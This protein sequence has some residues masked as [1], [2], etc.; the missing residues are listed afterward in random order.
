[1]LFYAIGERTISLSWSL[2]RAM[3]TL[4]NIQAQLQA[5]CG[6]QGLRSQQSQTAKA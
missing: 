3:F 6:L 1:V 5:D 4:L 2:E